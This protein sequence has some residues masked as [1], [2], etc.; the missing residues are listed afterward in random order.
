VTLSDEAIA[1]IEA[2][3][4][5]GHNVEVRRYKD[6][7]IVSEVRKTIKYRYIPKGD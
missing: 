3:L 4:K 5:R 2:A 1:A 6:G 7:V